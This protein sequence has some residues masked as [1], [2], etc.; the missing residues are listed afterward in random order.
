MPFL[1][2]KRQGSVAVLILLVQACAGGDKRARNLGVSF[3]RGIYQGCGPVFIWRV[4]A[5]AR[6][7]KAFTVS[8]CPFTAAS[9]RDFSSVF[10]SFLPLYI[11]KIWVRD[12]EDQRF[13]RSVTQVISDSATQ[14][15]ALREE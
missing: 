15:I 9:K 13:R 3:L 11:L 14:V 6:G 1:H 7:N 5:C 4:Q 12:S 10:I 8:A 2:C